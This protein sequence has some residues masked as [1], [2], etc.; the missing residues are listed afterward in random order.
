M[1][2][3][4]TNGSHFNDDCLHYYGLLYDAPMPRRTYAT[5]HPCPTRYEEDPTGIEEINSSLF[6]DITDPNGQKDLMDKDL[7]RIEEA[8][9]SRLQS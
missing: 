1:V 8:E 2:K 4:T 7:A 5:A 9:G 6:P 3:R